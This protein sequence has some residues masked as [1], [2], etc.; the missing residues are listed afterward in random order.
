MRKAVLLLLVL[1]AACAAAMAQ[2]IE[3][4]HD[5]FDTFALGTTWQA[6]DW[7]GTPG[8]PNVL[9]G[10]E[11]HSGPVTLHM[12]STSGTGTMRGIETAGT[13]DITGMVSLTLD[14]RTTAANTNNTTPVEVSLLGETGEWMRQYYTYTAWTNHYD[15]SSGNH[16][17]WGQWYSGMQPQYF[18][19]YVKTVDLD[20]THAQVYD[21]TG[22]LRWSQSYSGLTIHDLGSAADIVIRQHD[23]A[24]PHIWVD[25]ATLSGYTP[26]PATLTLL[27]LGGLGLLRRRK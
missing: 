15:D 22:A 8:A 27:A 21:E 23:A 11:A 17:A 14:V 16:S 2:P 12:A 5:G 1:A 20:G 3:L 10:G 7:G 24:N 26:E 18:R 6:T 9:I 13:I 25:Y 4:F 19:R